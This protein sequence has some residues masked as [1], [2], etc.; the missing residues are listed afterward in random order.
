M[1]KNTNQNKQHKIENIKIRKN[2]SNNPRRTTFYS[3]MGVSYICG[4]SVVDNTS[5]TFYSLMGVSKVIFSYY[6]VK[7]AV[8]TFYSLMGVSDT[9][10]RQ[11]LYVALRTFYSLMGVSKDVYFTKQPKEDN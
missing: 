4:T 7:I 2:P 10:R 1:E 3:L 5:L 11:T 6:P 9:A 8:K